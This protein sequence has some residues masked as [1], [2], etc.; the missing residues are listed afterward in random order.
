MASDARHGAFFCG[1]NAQAGW[2]KAQLHVVRVWFK[3][4][5]GTKTATSE[6]QLFN[7]FPFRRI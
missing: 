5:A 7:P 3:R 4:Q 2:R 6:S 1:A